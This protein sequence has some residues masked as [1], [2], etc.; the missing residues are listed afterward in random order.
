MYS[1]KYKIGEIP[2][3]ELGKD[4]IKDQPAP[5]LIF[6]HGWTSSKEIAADFGHILYK[7]GYRVIIPD[8]VNHGERTEEQPR[9]WEAGK[10]FN[11]IMRTADE[12]PQIAHY[13]L[14]QNLTDFVAV[15]GVSMGGII[16]NA[17][18]KNH[19]HVKIA[20]SMMG[21][22]C[23]CRYAE[24]VMLEGIE[25]LMEAST[26]FY[27]EISI[28]DERV[29]QSILN[30]EA[31]AIDNLLPDLEKYDLSLTPEKYNNRFVFYWHA[32]PDPLVPYTFSADFFERIK[33]LPIA[34][35]A[36]FF[37]SEKGSHLVP[38]K[39]TKGVRGF[40]EHYYQ[41]YNE[42]GHAPQEELFWQEININ[43]K[44]SIQ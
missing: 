34:K 33:D 30:Q 44:I 18:L 17:I 14:D 1:K 20:A 39:V 12:F 3:L 27:P 40:F 13:F 11:S 16:T 8:C 10:L 43:K 23:L 29:I 22:P 28:P 24:W 7:S 9:M 38:I 15:A 6:Y 19:P 31:D 32:R 25:N 35:Q 37:G 2:I 42:T 26:N 5:L 21:T 4:R 41:I 36:K